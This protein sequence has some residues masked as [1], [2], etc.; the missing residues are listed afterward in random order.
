MV[1]GDVLAVGFI[2]V[3]V[4]DEDF[5]DGMFAHG[6]TFETDFFSFGPGFALDGAAWGREAGD[7]VDGA[8]AEVVL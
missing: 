3:R 7:A 6:E 4:R 1:D 2:A 8:G 5:V